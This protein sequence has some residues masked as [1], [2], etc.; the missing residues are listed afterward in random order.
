MRRIAINTENASADQGI[1]T[2]NY[3]LTA[4][5]V[6]GPF[7]AIPE[8]VYDQEK[9]DCM[10]HESLGEKLAEQFHT[11]P[12][13]LELLN[14][15]VKL[16]D[17]QAGQTILAPAVRARL[18]AEELSRNELA[19]GTVVEELMKN[20]IIAKEIAGRCAAADIQRQVHAS[21]P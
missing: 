9:L 2:P 6:K 18:I 11:T 15:H 13:T 20:P 10:C 8:S 1:A 16:G 17:L 5:D 21:K 19:A 14:P 4:E 3:V 12:E 7:V